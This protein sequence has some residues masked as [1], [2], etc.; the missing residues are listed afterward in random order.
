[1]NFFHFTNTRFSAT[2]LLRLSGFPSVRDMS[3]P[4]AAEW[5]VT[6]VYLIDSGI[7][8]SLPRAKGQEHLPLCH[9]GGASQ[10]SSGRKIVEIYT[11]KSCIGSMKY[12]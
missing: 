12:S 8:P 11:S 3:Q 1:M 7:E 9:L 6:C 2:Q 4:M 10:Y 5:R